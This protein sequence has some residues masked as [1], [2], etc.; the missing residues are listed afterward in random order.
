MGNS[1]STEPAPDV[2][3]QDI[4]VEDKFEVS[5]FLSF[6]HLYYNNYKINFL[7]IFILLQIATNLVYRLAADSDKEA[8]AIPVVPLHKCK[9]LF[10]CVWY[11][12]L[13]ST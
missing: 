7:F 10:T 9:L 6:S 11:S 2:S 3:T 8:N 4:P 12:V 5:V 13:M 1:S